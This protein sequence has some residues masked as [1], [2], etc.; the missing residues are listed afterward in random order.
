M[1]YVHGIFHVYD[2]VVVDGQRTQDSL[3]E[4][5]ARGMLDYNLPYIIHG[6]ATGRHKDTRSKTSDWD[7]ID[8]FF[9]NYQNSKTGRAIRYSLDVPR[10]NPPIRTRHNDVNAMIC[11]A[12]GQRRL[13]VYKDAPTVDE[14]LRLTKLKS[15]SQYL[16]DDKD[17]YQ[18]ITT[19]LGYAVHGMLEGQNNKQM[20]TSFRR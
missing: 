16:E 19:A 1:Q 6:D 7:I 20:V 13:F 10:S 8:K 9:A 14:G 11:N 12:N 5:A 18:H 15:G 3:E 4:M 17:R 2:E